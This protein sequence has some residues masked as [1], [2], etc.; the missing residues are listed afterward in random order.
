MGTNYLSI[1]LPLRLNPRVGRQTGILEYQVLRGL[2]EQRDR[3]GG[4]MSLYSARR[5]VSIG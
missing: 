2:V 1:F 5:S 3:K 4:E